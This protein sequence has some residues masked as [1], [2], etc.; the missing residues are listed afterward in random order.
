M[1]L[2][3]GYAMIHAH[4]SLNGEPLIWPDPRLSKIGRRLLAVQDLIDH[5]EG[6][7]CDL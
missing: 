1:S 2:V 5:P 3:T 4:A 7:E 6:V